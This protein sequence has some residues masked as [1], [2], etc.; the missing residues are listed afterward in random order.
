MIKESERVIGC[1]RIWDSLPILTALTPQWLSQ[2]SLWMA[3]HRRLSTISFL[4]GILK[5]KFHQLTPTCSLP[6][7]CISERSKPRNAFMLCT[8][9]CCTLTSACI[10]KE[11]QTS[12][13]A[14]EVTNKFIFGKMDFLLVHQQQMTPVNPLLPSPT[15]TLNWLDLIQSCYPESNIIV[16]HFL[17][18][19]HPQYLESFKTFFH[20]FKT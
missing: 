11:K 3:A 16:M 6:S 20:L 19:A 7:R 14:A 2:G 13:T 4:L 8:R 17:H 18:L 9:F 10:P 1:N 12:S 15:C 5:F